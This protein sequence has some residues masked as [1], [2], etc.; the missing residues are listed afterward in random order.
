MVKREDIQDWVVAAL[1]DHNGSASIVQVARHI[2]MHHEKEL[3]TS[4]D[5][6]FTWQYD[7]RWACT[8]LREHKVVQAAE[9]SKRGQWCL[10]A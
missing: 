1:K 9:I 6:F 3:Q 7:M 4:G 5:L 2:W 8:R 10:T